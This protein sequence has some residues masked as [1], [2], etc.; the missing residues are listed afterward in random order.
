MSISP[1]EILLLQSIK[2]FGNVAIHAIIA[3]MLRYSISDDGK[4]YELLQRM[5]KVKMLKP[6]LPTLDQFSCAAENA[7]MLLEMSTSKGIR[8]LTFMD[9]DF[10]QMLLASVSEKGK[11]DVPLMI[12][13]IGNLNVAQKPSLAVV[14]TR[15]PNQAGLQASE[16][17]AVEYASRGV[18][19]VS[20]LALGCDTAAHKGALSVGGSTTA[21]LAGGLDS[22][23]PKEN[24]LL[25]EQILQN[26]GLLIS[27]HPVGTA[28]NKY[29]LVLRDRLQVAMADATLVVQT[30]ENGGTMHAARTTLAAGKPLL[31]VDYK[32]KTDDVVKGNIILRNTGAIELSSSRWK[33]NCHYYLDLLLGNKNKDGMATVVV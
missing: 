13:Y 16:F 15:D 17:F 24:A 9:P 32:D 33:E 6:Q 31:V 21:I 20:G 8:M 27:E 2:G 11:S 5:S 14:G 22:I 30:R 25:A 1:R 29:N 4:L 19:I 18:N 3:E 12:H 7:E 26:D 10:P 28:T 23:Y